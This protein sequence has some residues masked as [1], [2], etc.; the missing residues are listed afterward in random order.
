M[1]ADK[2]Q[3]A[4]QAYVYGYPLVYN[5]DELAKFPSGASTILPGVHPY[6]Q[7]GKA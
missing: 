5:L 1:T 7:I 6:N 4:A 2:V 3:L